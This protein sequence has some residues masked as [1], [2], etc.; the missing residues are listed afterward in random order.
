[1]ASRSRSGA[2]TTAA[3][4]ST[5]VSTS[6]DPSHASLS[7]TSGAVWSYQHSGQMRRSHRQCGYTATPMRSTNNTATIE[8]AIDAARRRV[9]ANCPQQ[10]A[11]AAPSAAGPMRVAASSIAPGNPNSPDEY[12]DAATPPMTAHAHTINNTAPI[13][14]STAALARRAPATPASTAYHR[15]SSS[16]PHSPR[17]PNST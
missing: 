9:L 12:A 17:A 8:P 3:V 13:P 2:I 16:S 15:P 5:R 7:W 4:A 14:A 11:S 6:A 1:G 10:A